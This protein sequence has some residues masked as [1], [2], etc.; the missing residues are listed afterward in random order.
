[1]TT[2]VMQRNIALGHDSTFSRVPLQLLSWFNV[3]ATLQECTLNQN[4]EPFAS[5]H[6]FSTGYYHVG[7]QPPFMSTGIAAPTYQRDQVTTNAYSI[8]VSAAYDNSRTRE[9]S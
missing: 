3:Q 8:N 4:A 5:R 6:V 9:L 7:Y 1:M 2:T